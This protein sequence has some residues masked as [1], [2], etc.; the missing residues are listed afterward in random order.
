[1][2]KLAFFRDQDLIAIPEHYAFT[3]RCPFPYPQTENNDSNR[4]Y[5][6]AAPAIWLIANSP[7]LRDFFDYPQ[8]F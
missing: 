3:L 1:M 5:W 7:T 2:N 8:M 4:L 6:V